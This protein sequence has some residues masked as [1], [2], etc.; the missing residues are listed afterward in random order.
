MNASNEDDKILSVVMKGC[1]F[2]AL[3]KCLCCNR[4]M[5]T[6][7]ASCIYCGQSFKEKQPTRIEDKPAPQ[8]TKIGALQKDTQHTVLLTVGG[9][10]LAFVGFLCYPLGFFLQLAGGAV[11]WKA[12]TSAAGYYQVCCPSCRRPGT[13]RGK[14][15]VYR[16]P[17]CFEE[18]KVIGSRLYPPTSK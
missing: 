18:S 17:A 1:L 15:T 8:P 12:N 9:L 6:R 7:I 11:L 2:M 10:A 5:S 14:S 4:Y 3:V 16:C 13:M